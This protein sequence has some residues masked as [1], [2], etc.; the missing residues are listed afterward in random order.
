MFCKGL[1]R[2]P[3]KVKARQAHRPRNFSTI[4]SFPAPNSYCLSPK[5]A[6]ISRAVPLLLHH[7][8]LWGAS[9]RVE[10]EFGPPVG[11]CRIS[12][13][14]AVFLISLVLI[15]KMSVLVSLLECPLLCLAYLV[16]AAFL[17]MCF[18]G[19]VCVCVCV[20]RFI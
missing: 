12:H 15:T 6:S 9:G 13:W 7:H 20:Y 1:C 2:T 11:F 17:T 16:R 5:L 4:H 18:A 14:R 19:S 3:R 8:F 10:E